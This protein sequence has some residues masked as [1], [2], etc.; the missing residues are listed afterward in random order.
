[1]D[2]TVVHVRYEG[3]VKNAGILMSIHSEDSERTKKGK[4]VL[5][6]CGARDVSSTGEALA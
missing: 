3:M 5:E 6:Q 2:S 1:M 4:A